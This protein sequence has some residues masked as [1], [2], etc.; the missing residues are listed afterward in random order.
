MSWPEPSGTIRDFSI[1][2]LLK[3]PMKWFLS[4]PV[5]RWCLK[6]Y[7]AKHSHAQQEGHRG[8]VESEAFADVIAI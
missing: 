3:L 8:P 5:C 2:G 7:R 6:K 1:S 4:L